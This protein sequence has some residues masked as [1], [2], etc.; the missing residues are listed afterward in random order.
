MHNVQI[1]KNQLCYS[2]MSSSFWNSL[3]QFQNSFH[4]FFPFHFEF[5]WIIEAEQE[6]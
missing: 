3:S 1:Q 5:I 4:I 2:L 6:S